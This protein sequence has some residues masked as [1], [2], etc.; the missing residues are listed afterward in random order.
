MA[1]SKVLSP[2]TSSSVSSSFDSSPSS[3]PSSIPPSSSSS[4]FLFPVGHPPHSGRVTLCRISDAE[5]RTTGILTKF[6][7]VSQDYSWEAKRKTLRLVLFPI[8]NLTLKHP[9]WGQFSSMHYFNWS[10]NR[11]GDFIDKNIHILT[12]SPLQ[13]SQMPTPK[14]PFNAYHWVI[15]DDP[16]STDPHLS[17][18]SHLLVL[19][20]L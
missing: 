20:P 14:L 9:Y 8:L 11:N 1:S 15:Y 10:T 2:H 3:S 18:E 6:V 7:Y 5:R 16:Y 12:Y 13:E 17:L 19:L 4:F